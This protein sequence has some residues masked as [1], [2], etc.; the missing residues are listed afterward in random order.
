MPN[1]KSNNKVDINWEIVD[2]L[3][4]VQCTMEE[5]AIVV[6]VD[7]E[8]IDR[9]CKKQNKMS[10]A[11]YYR[12]KKQGGK[13]SLRRAQ[14]IAAEQDRNTAMLIWLGKQYL[15]QS[16]KTEIIIDSKRDYVNKLLISLTDEDIEHGVLQL[17]QKRIARSEN[18]SGSRQE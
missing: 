11:E 3:C 10:F 4:S 6:N 8:T 13:A 7:E 5:V 17:D 14:W 2:R 15:G 12:T 9:H 1:R 16:E 18:D